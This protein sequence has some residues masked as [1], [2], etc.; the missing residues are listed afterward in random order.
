MKK[1]LGILI[2]LVILAAAASAMAD[3]AISADVFPD[4]AFREIVKGFDKDANGSLSDEEIADTTTIEC[5]GKGISSL[6]GIEVFTSLLKLD[7]S[8][9]QLQELNIRSNTAL[10]RLYAQ[11]ND[12]EELDVTGCAKLEEAVNKGRKTG[13]SEYDTFQSPYYITI[14]IGGVPGYRLDNSYYLYVDKQTKVTAGTN[15]SYGPG[16]ND[17]YCP[18]ETARGTLIAA[19]IGARDNERANNLFDGNGNTKLCVIVPKAY[20]IWKA[21]QAIRISGYDLMTGND[22][23]TYTDRNPKSWT[24]YGSNQLL[25]RYSSE[26]E[27]IDSVTNDTTLQGVDQTWF[28]FTLAK[29]SKKYQ[30][31]RLELVAEEGVTCMQ[32]S[33]VKLV[34]APPEE[35]SKASIDP[36]ADQIYTGSK[37]T[38]AVKVKFGNDFLT[39]G[40]D[41]KV[42]YKDNKNVGKATVTVTGIG[43]YTGT[44]TANFRINPQGVKL[45]SLKA[46][47]KQLT[48]KWDKGKNID[49]YEIEYSLKNTFKNSKKINIRKDSTTEYLIEKLKAKKTYYVRIR[50]FKKVGGKKY[51]SE[52]SK[53]KNKK[54]K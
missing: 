46:G 20:I 24:L 3:V 26:W 6:K 34:E 1:W 36:I 18:Y 19:T 30:Y 8:S 35:I 38:P 28:N 45:N 7:C 23:G 37:V 40:T 9:N 14:Y 13:N 51:Y 25:N 31:F 43:D 29:A 33:E 42:S 47:K 50:T 11:K 21:P 39:E 52:W 41:Y 49:G 32:L 22:T 10:Y 17:P 54:T 2:V 44:K 12:L 4:A 15:V 48:V 53:V 5:S 16:G 27:V